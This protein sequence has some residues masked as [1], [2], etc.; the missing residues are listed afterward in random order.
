M[1]SSDKTTFSPG[2]PEL[3][4]IIKFP[5]IYSLVI[6]IREFHFTEVTFSQMPT[7]ENRLFREV[8]QLL[9]G[10]GARPLCQSL[11]LLLN[12]EF[13]FQLRKNI[14]YISNLAVNV[15]FY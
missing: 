4:D 10:G 1:L 2:F 12:F 11:T 8:G 14:G 5:P 3:L 9:E 13:E 15:C 7:K 6:D